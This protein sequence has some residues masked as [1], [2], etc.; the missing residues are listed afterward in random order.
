MKNI[1]P[2]QSIL[3]GNFREKTGVKVVRKNDLQLTINRTKI[4][5]KL[6]GKFNIYN[7]LAAV[8]TTLA[9]GVDMPTIKKAIEETSVIVGR[10]QKVISG[11]P[12]QNFDVFVDYAHTV[13]SLTKA[14]EALG[15]RRKI[16]V[17][18]SCG[19]GRD[20]WKRPQMGEVAGKFCD[21]I[22]LTNDFFLTFK[23]H[24]RFGYNHID[25]I[26]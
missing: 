18:G 2:L 5:S 8:K 25:C 26:N 19:G 13:D 24:P 14:Y 17:L 10:M 20:K 3:W 15:N 1:H 23:M 22:I 21:K 4:N 6:I 9:F 7:I 12:K 11:N 16:C